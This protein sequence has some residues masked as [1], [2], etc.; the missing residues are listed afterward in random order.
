MEG[1]VLLKTWIYRRRHKYKRSHRS[2]RNDQKGG[3]RHQKVTRNSEK[4]ARRR[5][6]LNAHKYP[7]ACSCNCSGRGMGRGMKNGDGIQ[8]KIITASHEIILRHK[9]PTR[10]MQATPKGEPKKDTQGSRACQ[11]GKDIATQLHSTLAPSITVSSNA[12]DT[13]INSKFAS[14]SRTYKSNVTILGIV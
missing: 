10:K 12:G 9:M 8:V 5:N 4:C 11:T 13:S 2:R 14:L 1:C 6:T 7:S 3:Q